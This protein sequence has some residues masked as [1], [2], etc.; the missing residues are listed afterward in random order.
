MIL[1][2]CLPAFGQGG[3]IQGRVFNAINNESIEFATVGVE[4]TAFGTSTDST[5]SFVLSGLQPGIY[6]L[7]ISS[8]AFKPKTIFEIQVS[9][10]A[11]AEVEVPLESIATELTEV[12]VKS[13]AFD[14]SDESPVSLRTIGVSEIQRNPGGNR[15]ISRVI[16]SFPGVAYTVSFRNDVIIRGGAPNENRFYLDDVEVPT[17]NHFATQGSSGGPV[18]MINVDFIKEV[19]FYSGA[20]PADKGSG[21][22]SLFEFKQRDGRSDRI[23]FT[24]TVGSSDLGLTLEGPIGDRSNFIFSIRRSYLQLLFKTLELPFLPTY[25]DYQLKYKLRFDKKNEL[26]VISL[27]A[28]DHNVLN[29]SANETPEQQYILANLP[30]QDQWNYTFGLAYKHYGKNNFVTVVASRNMLN[31]E[32]TKYQNNDESDEDNLLLNYTSQEIENKFRVENNWY[33]NKLKLYYGG[34]YEFVKYNNTTYQKQSDPAGNVFLV[35]FSSDIAFSKFAGFAQ[36]S[37]PFFDRRLVTSFGLR[38]DFSDYD[39]SMSNPLS[40]ISPRL[41][42]TYNINDQFNLNFNTGIY[43]QLPPYTVM[44]YRSNEGELVNKENNISYISNQQLV[45]GGEYY[46]AN[47]G[48][49][50][51]EGFYKR[52]TN[53]PFLLQDSISLANLGAD[54][55]VIGNE[56][57]VSTSEGRSYGVELLLQQKIYRGF[58]GLASFTLFRSEFKDK[59][60][61][62]VPSSWDNRFITALTAGKKFSRNWELGVKWRFSAGSPYT[63][64][65]TVISALIPV[66]NVNNSG[67]PDY[68]QLNSLRIAAYNQLDVRVDKKWFLPKFSINLYL[69]IQNLLNAKVDLPPF[70]D[71]VRDENGIPVEDPNNPGSYDVYQLENSSG[72]VLPSI[73]LVFAY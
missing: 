6:N 7:K 41:S 56:P 52:Y 5:G 50:S 71:V 28:L 18:G 55:G 33:K 46:S 25:N 72:T 59:K 40:Q 20:F 48:R 37:Y 44:G 35:N 57:A 26:S 23:G 14:K 22:S 45:F 47:G 32:A 49:I 30:E 12:F 62:Y 24:A 31:N 54:F 65:D 73:G 3:K 2:S 61:N 9:N 64:Y 29:L 63:P 38:T 39:E 8:V 43:H 34:G 51:L 4:G 68:D 11:P 67:V 19:E 27:G 70:L 66:W 21:L 16:Q 13:D 36:I 53:Y 58:Y 69:D 15:D 60:Q 42:L 1:I 10:S 17:I